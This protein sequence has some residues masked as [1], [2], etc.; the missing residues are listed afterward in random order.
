MTTITDNETVTGEAETTGKAEVPAQQAAEASKVDGRGA[1]DGKKRKG[2]KQPK[3]KPAAENNA[4]DAVLAPAAE[5][6]DQAAS[7]E[8]RQVGKG[9]PGK[10]ADEV[11]ASYPNLAAWPVSAGPVPL[12]THILTARALGMGA[13]TKRELAVAAYLRDEASQFTLVQVGEALRAVLGGEFNVQRNVANSLQSGGLVKINKVTVDEGTSYRL[14]LT[15]K[16]EA[17]VNKWLVE[18]E[19]SGPDRPKSTT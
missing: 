2:S 5:V 3:G 8:G 9:E 13:G 18:H 11:L 16:G 4:A 10:P 12:Q 19:P 7:A 15:A 6:S 1:Q 17:K 14:E